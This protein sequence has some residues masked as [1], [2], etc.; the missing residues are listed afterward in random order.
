[1]GSVK[2]STDGLRDSDIPEVLAGHA[3][4]SGLGMDV[5]LTDLQ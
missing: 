1:V 3:L 2:Y 4:A 5:E